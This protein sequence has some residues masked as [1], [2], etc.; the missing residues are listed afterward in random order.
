MECP[1]CGGLVVIEVGLL[2]CP[3]CD[4]YCGEADEAE[5]GDDGE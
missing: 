1:Y 4:V 5:E 3:A 2:Y